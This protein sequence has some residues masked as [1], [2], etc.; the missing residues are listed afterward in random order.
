MGNSIAFFFVLAA[1]FE[2]IIVSK[3]V[4]RL[5]DLLFAVFSKNQ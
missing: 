4:N 3:Y 1:F 5:V 2:E